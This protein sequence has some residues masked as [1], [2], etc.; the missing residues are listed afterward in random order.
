MHL[1]EDSADASII[2]VGAREEL[3]HLSIAR[4]LKES[5]GRILAIIGF[6]AILGA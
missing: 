3:H 5:I 2:Q 1:V 6:V 4:R